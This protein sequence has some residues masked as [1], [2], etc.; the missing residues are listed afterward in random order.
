MEFKCR[1]LAIAC[2]VVIRGETEAELL[3]RATAH[4]LTAHGLSV[5]EH[6]LEELKAVIRPRGNA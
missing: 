2:N 1:D 5:D 4:A 3:E 6:L